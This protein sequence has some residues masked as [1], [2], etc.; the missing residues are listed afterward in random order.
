MPCLKYFGNKYDCT[1]MISSQLNYFKYD[2]TV[3]IAIRL[4]I[5]LHPRAYFE[6]NSQA[7]L[8]KYAGKICLGHISQL[9]AP[10]KKTVFISFRKVI[11]N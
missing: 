1:L 5:S 4:L 9:L 3:F 8:E 11:N 10:S 7:A 2:L 6:I